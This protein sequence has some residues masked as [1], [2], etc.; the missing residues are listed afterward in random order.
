MPQLRLIVVAVAVAVA[1][2]LSCFC[3]LVAAV[4]VLVVAAVVATIVRTQK[5][6]TT[7]TRWLVVPSGYHV[8]DHRYVGCCCG[9]DNCC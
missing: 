6:T 7:A 5:L 3:C 2:V 4:A 9:W 1:V 8:G